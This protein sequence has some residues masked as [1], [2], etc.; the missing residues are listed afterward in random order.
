MKSVKNIIAWALALVMLISVGA[1]N[2]SAADF[3][4][5]VSAPDDTVGVGGV[6]KVSVTV[7][8]I[9]GEAGLLSVDVPLQYDDTVFECVGV[10]AVY[11]EVWGNPQNFSYSQYLNG[12]F[13]LRMVNDED[14]FGADSGCNQG[15][16]M[17]FDVRLR[18]KNSAALGMTEISV[19]GDNV[20][21][22][23]SATL[24]DG[25]CTPVYGNG[26]SISLEV[27]EGQGLLGDVNGD[28]STDNLDAAYTLRHDANLI[29]LTETQMAIADVNGD[30][31]V[32]SLDA[33]AIL[34]FDAGLITQFPA[35]Q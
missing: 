26:N 17:R 16:V 20:Y 19:A 31:Q 3:T 10:D 32:N 15:G 27:V 29:Q 12:V 2:V 18:V 30:G 8:S 4:V 5:S 22:V 21:F 6:I 23:P 9:S 7:D 25:M 14:S 1:L 33:A 13:W 28:G 11:P 34:R 24:A 35:Q